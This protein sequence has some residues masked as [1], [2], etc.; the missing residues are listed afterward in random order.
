MFFGQ[1]PQRDF[2]IDVIFGVLVIQFA[3]I[4]ILQSSQ[5]II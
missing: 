1:T 5:M 4:T 3:K 2:A